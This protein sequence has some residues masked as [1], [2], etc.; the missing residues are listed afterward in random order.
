MI[1]EEAIERVAFELSQRLGKKVR[2]EEI[3]RKNMYPSAGFEN[4]ASTHFGQPLW[5]CDLRERWDR[6]YAASQFEERSKEVEEFNKNNR[7]RKRG[8]SMTSLKYGIGFKQLAALN[9]S[10][11]VVQ[12][13]KDDGSVTIVH[14]GVEMGQGLHT[15][16]AQVAA[17]ELGIG[18]EFVRVTGNNT[19][20]INNAAPTAASTGFDLNGGAVAAACRVLKGRL[21]AFCE[22][23]DS[24]LKAAGIDW[25]K[26]WRD[27]W[28]K[29]VLQAWLK[30]VPLISAEMFKAPHYE[31]PVENFPRGKFFAYFAYGFSVSEVEIDVLT[32][33]HTVLRA[34]LLY[35][36][37]QSPNP[38]I[39]IGQI[40]GGYVQG[41]GFMTTEEIIYDDS[42]KLITDNIWTYKPPC[43]KSIPLDM[44]VALAD[45][46]PVSRAA[47]EKAGLLAVAASKSAAEPTLSLGVSAYFAIKQAVRAARLEQTGK[48]EWVRLDVPA[49]CQRIQMGCAVSP[50]KMTL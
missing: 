19:D 17:K 25:R 7:W 37:G 28:P 31:Q 29:M 27:C 12:I 41:L 38:A 23:Y 21:D 34:D 46:D 5:F 14:G 11:A 18:L 22:A 13:N 47:Q 16:I 3:R 33:E 6:H 26:E 20:T 45:T 43:S 35:D 49:T 32:G 40:E 1:Q 24:D 2:A 50:E 15:K 9:T 4:A 8:I 36:A 48:E 30:R 44:R 39:D 42:G 10:S